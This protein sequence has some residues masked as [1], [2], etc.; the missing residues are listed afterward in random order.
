MTCDGRELARIRNTVLFISAITW[1]LLLFEP[2]S[3]RLMIHCPTMHGAV[4]GFSGALQTSSKIISLWLVLAG[5]LL[6]LAAMMSPV[7]I[8]P[9]NY[10]CLRS[11]RNRRLRS[12]FLFTLGYAVS[13]AAA[14]L[15]LLAVQVA[16]LL[17]APQ[18][19][20]PAAGVAIVAIIWQFSPIKQCCL[21]RCYAH[22]ALAAFGRGADL[23]ALRF[24]VTHGMWCAGS[25]WAIMLIP[26]LLPAGHVL[27]MALI[28]V[29]IFSERL[30]S[31]RPPSWRCRGLRT[32]IRILVAQ[33]RIRL[34][35]PTVG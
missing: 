31:P 27:A 4:T 25:C 5:W 12:T 20:L 35:A 19:F 14:G 1:I 33:S 17:F 26:L 7:L 28:S 13:W 6:M 24:G 2:E 11:F 23:D 29:L 15:V 21:N 16:V 10:I 34:H 32:A 30:E 18:S 3:M 9:I 8:L 22:P